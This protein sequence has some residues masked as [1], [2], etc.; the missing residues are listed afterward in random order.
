MRFPKWPGP[1]LRVTVSVQYSRDLWDLIVLDLYD[2]LDVRVAHNSKCVRVSIL[3]E[4]EQK[5]ILFLN[6]IVYIVNC[7]TSHAKRAQNSKINPTIRPDGPDFQ[8]L[9]PRFTHAR[10][11]PS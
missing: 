2:H 8:V 1:S 7:E 6:L 11:L 9:G 3:Q 5:T 10:K 4:F